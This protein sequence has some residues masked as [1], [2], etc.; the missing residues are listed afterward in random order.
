MLSEKTI[1]SFMDFSEKLV[2]CKF[3]LYICDNFCLSVSEDCGK[4]VILLCT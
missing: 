2:T 4:E 3:F 1:F